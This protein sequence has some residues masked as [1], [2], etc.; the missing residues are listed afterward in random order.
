MGVIFYYS[1]NWQSEK[2]GRFGFVSIT[3]G[4]FVRAFIEITWGR[5]ETIWE[6]FSLLIRNPYGPRASANTVRGSLIIS[7]TVHQINM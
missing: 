2:D 5:F 1:R 3:T 4:T 6:Q 7:K